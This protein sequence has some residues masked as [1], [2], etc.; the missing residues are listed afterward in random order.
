MSRS[1]FQNFVQLSTNFLASIALLL[2]FSFPSDEQNTDQLPI[3]NQMESHMPSTFSHTLNFLMVSGLSFYSKI[4]TYVILQ[5][6]VKS[7]I[8]VWLLG[9]TCFCII[10][11]NKFSL[12]SFFVFYV[13]FFRHVFPGWISLYN[14]LSICIQSLPNEFDVH[15]FCDENRQLV[16]SPVFS[17]FQFFPGTSLRFLTTWYLFP[18]PSI[19]FFLFCI[20]YS[21]RIV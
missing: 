4:F 18:G 15:V 16:F 2:D 9:F 20:F 5:V 14:I 19:S 3:T 10:C 13:C 1:A 6:V 8:F 17:Y 11:L 12:Y 21:L 7:P